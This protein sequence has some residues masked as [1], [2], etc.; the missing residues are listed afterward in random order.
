MITLKAALVGTSCVGVLAVGG[1]TYATVAH[2]NAGLRSDQSKA[3]AAKPPAAA[4]APARPE[5]LPAVPHGLPKGGDVK[6]AVPQQPAVPQPA[7]P[8]PGAAQQE[9]AGAQQ[10]ARQAAEQHAQ[11]VD[12]ARKAP[13]GQPHAMPA[14]PQAPGANCLP[15][16]L[17]KGAPSH[18][19][20]PAK[21]ALPQLPHSLKVSCDSVKP[22]VALGGAAERSIIVARGL[23]HGTKKVEIIT[24]KAH[25]LCKVTEK[26]TGAAGQWLK[27]ETLKTP[28]SFSLDQVRLALRM[29]AGGAPVNVHGVHGWQ[30][31]L[32]GAV[33]WYSADGYAVCVEASPA[34]APQLQDV[35]AKL[36]QHLAQTVR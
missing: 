25:K 19:A 20:V 24:H 36:Q 11:Q 14:A 30:T 3:P 13:A 31:S 5:C 32:G 4:P 6:H 34:Y 2:P 15:T 33:I 28:P 22:A 9:V 17:P 8:K 7:A 18:P 10:A 27:V 26:W 21:P 23:S 16:D 12:A 29:P 35:A 1:I